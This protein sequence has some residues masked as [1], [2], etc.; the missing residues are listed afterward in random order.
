MMILETLIWHILHTF[1]GADDII[2]N[3]G[4]ASSRGGGGGGHS[5]NF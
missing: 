5:H 4:V 1:V 3:S 2:T